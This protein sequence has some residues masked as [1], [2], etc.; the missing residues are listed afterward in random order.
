MKLAIAIGVAAMLLA[1]C[2]SSDPSVVDQSESNISEDCAA[3]AAAAEDFYLPPD[4]LPRGQPG[5][6]IRCEPFTTAMSTVAKGTRIMYLSTNVHGDPIA[7]TGSVF[8]PLA[9]WSGAGPRPLLGFTTGTHGQGDQCAPSRLMAEVVAYEPPL[10]ALIEYETG[11]ILDQLSQGVAVA[12]T[13]YQGLGTPG[14][15][16]WLNRSAE[17]HANIDAVR[18]ARRLPGTGIPAQGPVAFSGYSQGG[19]A[20]AATAELLDAYGS[21]LDVVGIYAGA[22]PSDIHQLVEYL[23]GGGAAG[24]VGYYLNGLAANYPEV[25][26]TL[27]AALND[28]GKALRAQTAGQCIIGTTVSYGFQQSSQYTNSGETFADLLAAPAFSSLVAKDRLG[29][30]RPSVPVLLATGSND[31]IVPPAGMRRLADDWCARG[32]TVELYD[33]PL[34]MVPGGTGVGHVANGFA[35]YLKAKLWL[36][37]R[38]AGVPATSSCD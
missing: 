5:D 25:N 15:H 3:A 23:D 37:D 26:G 22:V 32:A 31:E 20:A 10:D 14:D 38:F 8:E 4:P 33:V 16:A 35:L 13:D 27:D 19:G 18:A 12:V 29:S 28:A 9:S 11:F 34:P 7:V 30:V 6:V 21:E 1:A 24:Y 36:Q 2:G 17:A